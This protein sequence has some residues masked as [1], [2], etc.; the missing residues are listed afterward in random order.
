MK[1]RQSEEKRKES[2]MSNSICQTEVILKRPFDYRVGD[3]IILHRS[4]LCC[5]LKF[6]LLNRTANESG[7]RMATSKNDHQL[8][9]VST[10]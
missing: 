2:R 1:T 7:H 5:L 10:N 3:T 6:D 8:W 9:A 4:G